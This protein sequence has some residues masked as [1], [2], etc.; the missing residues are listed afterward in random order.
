VTCRGIEV[1]LKLEN[2][3]DYVLVSIDIVFNVRLDTFS[4]WS[5]RRIR[6][7]PHILIYSAQPP[8]ID[9][10]VSISVQYLFILIER[11]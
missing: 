7:T 6:G 4:G 9:R 10:H 1:I 3:I 5:H 8:S 2:R 11:K